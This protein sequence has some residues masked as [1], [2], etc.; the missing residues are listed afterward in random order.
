MVVDKKPLARLRI[1]I[2]L[3]LPCSACRWVV[4]RT[5]AEVKKKAA[6]KF[7]KPEEDIIL[8]QVHKP[9]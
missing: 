3:T 5:E 8:S 1:T 7:G 6:E 4:G 2:S 9:H